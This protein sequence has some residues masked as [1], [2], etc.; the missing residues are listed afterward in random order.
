VITVIASSF[1]DDRNCDKRV[2]ESQPQRISYKTAAMADFSPPVQK[3]EKGKNRPNKKSTRVDLTPMVDLGFLLITFFIFTT[4][5]G[6][7]KTLSLLLPDDTPTPKP[8]EVAKSAML[9]LV[10]DK[11]DRIWYYNAD[12][13][14]NMKQTYYG[15]E[16]RKIVIDKKKLVRQKLGK[17]D[18]M[19]IIIKPT[20]GSSVK[21]IV[22]IMD[23]ILINAIKHYAIIEPL[24]EDLDQIQKVYN[25]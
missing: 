9:Q 15:S 25:N 18:D 7:P 22:D 12:T 19:F 14:G 4:K 16:L 17:E 6:E 11:D 13:V 10:L 21:N 8:N 1:R 3:N 23:E 2:M 24:N 20:S 5:M